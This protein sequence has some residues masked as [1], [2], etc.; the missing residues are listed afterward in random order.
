MKC[1]PRAPLFILEGRKKLKTPW[2]FAKS[3]FKNYKPDNFKL[4]EECFDLDW[5]YTKMDKVIERESDE[6]KKKI[7]DYLRGVFK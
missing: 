4:L 7:K 5:N 3:V 1:I 2:D 6:E